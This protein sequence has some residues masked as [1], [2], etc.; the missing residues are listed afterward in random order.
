MPSHRREPSRIPVRG[1]L[2]LSL[3]LGGTALLLSFRGPEAGDV[4]LA[5][6]DTQALQASSSAP[7]VSGPLPSASTTAASA[8]PDPGA[9]ASPG[10]SP[11][12]STTTSPEPSPSPSA[13]PEPE[14]V[15][16]TGDAYSFRFGTVQVAVTLSG[17]DIIEVE[18][19]SLPDSDRHSLMIS[20]YVEPILREEAVT[21]DS[22]D[23][24]V[25]SG[26]TYTSR[27]Y[28]ASLQS[29]LDQLAA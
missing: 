10:A 9:T 21:A 12:A 25:I 11:A 18:A 24:D 2:A 5:I 15:T 28:A 26:A 27:A 3:T 6:A 16:L 19:L 4:A 23:I 22:A 29:A 17:S 1:A 8:S 14:L 20:Q 13:R 7:A